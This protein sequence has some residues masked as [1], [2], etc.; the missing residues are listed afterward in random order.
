M[1]LGL[2]L[3]GVLLAVVVPSQAGLIVGNLDGNDNG[4]S[5]ANT[6]DG[7][8]VKAMGFTM[9]SQSYTITSATLRLRER[10][11]DGQPDIVSLLLNLYSDV[12]GQPGSFL[13]TFTPPA[14]PLANTPTNYVFT[15]VGTLTLAAN[16]S[17]WMLFNF[18]SAPGDVESG[19]YGSIPNIPTTGP[20][21]TYLGSKRSVDNLATWQDSD[22][23]NSY[24]L[25]GNP[26]PEPGTLALMFAGVAG[27]VVLRKRFA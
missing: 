9:A 24:Q 16:Q 14:L 19:W 20:G 4:Y 12:L 18:V 1:K 22:L 7:P 21:G 10:Y 6:T 25:D 8:Y 5:R 13:G 11:T 17:Y 2:T 3:A 26:V 23:T 15:P 27:I